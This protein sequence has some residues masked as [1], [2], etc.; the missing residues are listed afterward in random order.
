MDTWEA[1]AAPKASWMSPQAWSALLALN[2][3]RRS[4]E[5]WLKGN[6]SSHAMALAV[7]AVDTELRA[8]PTK[9]AHPITFPAPQTAHHRMHSANVQ[10]GECIVT[11]IDAAS[12]RLKATLQHQKRAWFHNQCGRLNTLYI[13]NQPRQ[14][15]QALR[16]LLNKR[17][18]PHRALCLE[19]D[20]VT[21]DKDTLA[22]AWSDH[23]KT[24]FMA[25]E[26]T[27]N[28]FQFH[29]PESDSSTATF[30]VPQCFKLTSESVQQ[31]LKHT[32][33][34]KSSPD[35]LSRVLW[36]ETPGLPAAIAER[37]NILM[38][39]QTLPNAFRGSTIVAVPKPNKPLLKITSYRPV[40]LML[41]EAKIYARHILT[42]LQ[43][44]LSE[45]LC[46][47]QFATG[48]SPGSDLAHYIINQLQAFTGI[49]GLSTGMVFVDLKA[50]YDCLLRE[51]LGLD[52]NIELNAK[53]VAALEGYNITRQDATAALHHVRNHP[54]SLVN[55][56]LP[57]FMLQILRNWT[58][59][60]WMQLPHTK[61]VV[62]IPLQE[63]SSAPTSPSLATH[64]GLR[65]GDNLSSFL[66]T[67]HLS[68]IMSVI[69]DHLLTKFPN[70]VIKL[71]VPA[72]RNFGR[73]SP[74][75]D[76]DVYPEPCSSHCRLPAFDSSSSI[77]FTHIDFADDIML[78]L[79]GLDPAELV[80]ATLNTLAFTEALFKQYHFD[81]N[82]GSGKT[83]V[84]L[85]L[86]GRTAR[87]VWQKLKLESSKLDSDESV[88]EVG[89]ESRMNTGMAVKFTADRTVTVTHAYKYLG[90]MTSPDG[91]QETEVKTRLQTLRNT[92]RQHRRILTSPRHTLTTRLHFFQSIIRPHAIHWH[93]VLT[94]IKFPLRQTV[95]TTPPRIHVLPTGNCQNTF[96]P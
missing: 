3:L 94:Y 68:V 17:K 89:Q 20:S 72:F 54:L 50:A 51:L 86:R 41:S 87:A 7:N 16:L 81:L 19:G 43:T 75:C 34:H 67:V 47:H 38:S 80:Q 23:W 92:F 30:D 76:L 39:L 27:C 55:A 28:G 58:E 49:H 42:H 46:P 56:S 31:I 33:K 52:D 66:F 70:N 85:H 73:S 26:S 84:A 8:L 78:P 36:G 25:T 13:L 63:R 4:H 83:Q 77:A 15:H 44:I 62:H 2:G 71:P 14:L 64:T 45:Q 6:V 40:Q 21:T 12:R 29:R 11:Y 18:V 93:T 1:K 57:P 37:L 65:Q 79:I 61:K 59:S 88:D 9:A 60:A 53:S 69:H 35:T 5:Q 22:K 91:S 10:L 24:H 96:G 90:R 32:P 48:N 95:Q 82:Y 74:G